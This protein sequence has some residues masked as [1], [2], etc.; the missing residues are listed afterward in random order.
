MGSTYPLSFYIDT[1][2]MHAGNN[3]GSIFLEND[4]QKEE[5]QVWASADSIE[6]RKERTVQGLQRATYLLTKS[7]INFRLKKIV[8]G[9]WTK[10]T[11]AL[12]QRMEE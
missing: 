5:F 1:E 3:F 9:E 4:V 7:Y 8:T 2:Q 11:L 10:Q 6:V 12:I